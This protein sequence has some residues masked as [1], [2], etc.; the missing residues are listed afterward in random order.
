MAQTV[1]LRGDTQRRFAKGLIDRAPVD[2]VVR[3][4]EATRNADQ[5]ARMWAM[6]SDISR[7]K[8]EGRKWVPEVWKCAFMQS[9][10]H[11]VQFC[12]GLDGSGPFPIGFRSS[13]LTVRQMADLITVIAEYGDRHGVQWM[14]PERA[15]A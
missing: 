10:G 11:Q 8:P 15:D 9:L 6:L 12:E 13:R 1:I 5:N 7:A 14:E 4:S 2:A 3:I